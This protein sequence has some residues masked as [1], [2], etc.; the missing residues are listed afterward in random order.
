MTQA[1][2]AT[3]G[4][5]LSCGLCCNGVIFADV[6]LQPGDDAARLQSLGLTAPGS[7]ARGGRFFQPC[8]A[9]TDCKCRI[10]A[11]RPKHCR[12]FECALL[13]KVKRGATEL[14]AAQRSIRS[15]L[16]KADKVKRLLSEL[17]D[18]DEGT[19][20]RARFHRMAK[21]MAEGPLDERAADTYGELTLAMHDLNLLLSREF[22][23]S[24]R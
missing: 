14:A 23:P 24:Q 12:Q 1:E 21:R 8:A 2:Q 22:Y 19:A 16:Q 3:N 13:Q 15:A 20:L 9:F 7:G 4:L 18:T 11:D 5:C 17:G 6:K 10:Y